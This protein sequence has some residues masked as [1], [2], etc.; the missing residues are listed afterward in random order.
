MAIEDLVSALKS[1]G[2]INV[3]LVPGKVPMANVIREASIASHEAVM[4]QAEGDYAGMVPKMPIILESVVKGIYDGMKIKA[5]TI[6]IDAGEV[7]IITY[8]GPEANAKGYSPFLNP[9]AIATA[10]KEKTFTALAFPYMNMGGADDPMSV[11]SK[12]YIPVGALFENTYFT[13]LLKSTSK[14]DLVNTAVNDLTER[15]AAYKSVFPTVSRDQILKAA[16][17]FELC[18]R[19]QETRYEENRI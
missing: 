13:E 8:D 6:N 1:A 5:A 15:N 14:S 18:W 7:I 2:A 16:K 17:M 3:E 9:Y 4:L 10:V 19:V 11:P 12:V